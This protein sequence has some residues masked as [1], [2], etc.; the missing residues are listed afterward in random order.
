MIVTWNDNTGFVVGTATAYTEKPSNYF[1]FPSHE[2]LLYII[3]HC[4]NP[5]LN[6]IFLKTFSLLS[7]LLY[8]S[9][10]DFPGTPPEEWKGAEEGD[11][12]GT[13][14]V[15]PKAETLMRQRKLH[16]DTVRGIS[17]FHQPPIKYARASGTVHARL[18]A[19]KAEKIR[20]G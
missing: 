4:H 16:A 12:A 5:I 18:A 20:A 10:C 17:C 8:V 2:N 14:R 3:Q 1:S 19:K 15:A 9:C 7:F 11:A 13:G 6:S